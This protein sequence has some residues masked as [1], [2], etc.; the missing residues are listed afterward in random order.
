MLNANDYLISKLALRR[1][2]EIMEKARVAFILANSQV[3]KSKWSGRIM[4]KSGKL[5]II[6][7]QRLLAKYEPEFKPQLNRSHFSL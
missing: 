1:E 2:E 4:A 7:G 5:L 3:E 6:L